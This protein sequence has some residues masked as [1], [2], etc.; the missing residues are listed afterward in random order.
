MLSSRITAAA[1]SFSKGPAVVVAQRHAGPWGLSVATLTISAARSI[2]ARQQGGPSPRWSFHTGLVL[3]GCGVFNVVEGLINHQL[4]GI[5]HVRD[6]LG[7][8]LVR[9]LGFLGVSRVLAPAGWFLYW[10][11]KRVEIRASLPQYSKHA[12]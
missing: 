9:D 7:G 8:A 4:L 12:D 1:A 3:A 11:G 6:D 5:H 10:W 2:R